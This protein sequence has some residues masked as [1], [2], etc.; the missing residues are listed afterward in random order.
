MT[1]AV[2]TTSSAVGLGACSEVRPGGNGEVEKSWQCFSV[3]AQNTIS[4]SQGPGINDLCL[5]ATVAHCAGAT[6]K[7]KKK[8]P[9]SPNIW[10]QPCRS[11]L[12]WLSVAEGSSSALSVPGLWLTRPRSGRGL[13]LGMRCA[14]FLC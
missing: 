3:T 14:Y 2:E 5:S 6:N 7:K 11:A 13:L 9:P 4:G 1:G 8:A 10:Q 12:D